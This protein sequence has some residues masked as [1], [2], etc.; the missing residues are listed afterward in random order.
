MK[1]VSHLLGGTN[2]A[3]C[4]NHTTK[5]PPSQKMVDCFHGL[6]PSRTYQTILR[7]H[8]WTCTLV[9]SSKKWQS[10]TEFNRIDEIRGITTDDVGGLSVIKKKF[11][12]AY[13]HRS[14]WKVIWVFQFHNKNKRLEYS[15]G[16]VGCAFGNTQRNFS[17]QGAIIYKFF[18]QLSKTKL[19]R[20]TLL[21]KRRF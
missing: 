8:C 12:P 13:T 15:P 19:S 20:K 21:W 11:R 17:A 14:N 18:R 7:S 6:L 10:S 16:H 9:L 4:L 2:I 5:I 1:A 3:F